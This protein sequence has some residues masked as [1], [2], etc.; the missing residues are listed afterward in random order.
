MLKLFDILYKF[1]NGK[2]V[3]TLDA[4]IENAVVQNIDETGLQELIKAAVQYYNENN[5]QVAVEKLW[6]AFERLKTY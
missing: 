4:K 3:N 2:I 1:E 5:K 6:D